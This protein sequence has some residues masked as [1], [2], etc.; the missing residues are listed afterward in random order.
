M[1]Y[2]DSRYVIAHEIGGSAAERAA[3]AIAE[4]ARAYH[5]AYTLILNINTQDQRGR[6]AFLLR[7]KAGAGL[8]WPARSAGGRST[9]PS[10]DSASPLYRDRQEAHAVQGSSNAGRFRH[11]A[12]RDTCTSLCGAGAGRGAR[13]IAVPFGI[14][15]LKGTRTSLCIGPC[16]HPASR[17]TRTS[18]CIAGGAS[19]VTAG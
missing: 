2:R 19:A 3:K 13:P 8:P 16:R 18:L 14:L 15:P 10:Y 9:G 6:C 7:L 12:S 5:N 1:S 17:D 4:A 11:P